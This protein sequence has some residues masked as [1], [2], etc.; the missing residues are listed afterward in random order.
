MLTRLYAHNFRCFLNFELRPGSTGLLI[1]YNGSGKTSVFDVLAAIQDLLVHNQEAVEAFPADTLTKLEE[2]ARQR[3]ELDFASEVGLLR[4]T[5]V[6]DHRPEYET[7][8]IASESVVV[9]SANGE[10]PLYSFERGE[11]RLWG[12]A[13][14]DVHTIPFTNERSFLASV[15]EERSH[16]K[17]TAFL[18]FIERIW[19]LKLNPQS[20]L[21]SAKRDESW[22]RVDGANFPAWCRHL[23][24]ESRERVDAA[25]QQLREVIP[26]FRSLNVQAAGRVRVLVA[27]FVTDGKRSID[28]DFD[29]L[30]DGQRA[31][32]ILYVALHAVRDE[33][34]LLCLDEPDNFVS[35]R[36][37]Q[38][39][40]VE[41]MNTCDE[42]GLQALIISHASEVIDF[43]GPSQALLLERPEGGATRVAG[44][45][46]A[47]G[48]RLSERMARGWHTPPD[49]R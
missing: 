16:P 43:L 21:S 14:G 7:C 31:L 26:G 22:L 23:L 1:G 28:L 2:S 41:L 34:R 15:D 9:Q 6:L 12:A 40:L 29:R 42:G 18:E 33:A 46:D 45:K 48:L 24:L 25:E 27:R 32:V 3:F 4:Y 5:L 8:V 17:L 38:P 11:V 44:V 20:V 49:A 10:E 37:I 19:I 13:A 47:P 35:I 39:F 36:E 30:S